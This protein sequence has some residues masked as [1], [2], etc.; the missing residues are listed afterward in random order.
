VAV[1]P[2]IPSDYLIDKPVQ[3]RFRGTSP[4]AH[5]ISCQDQRTRTGGGVV[6][7]APGSSAAYRELHR[8]ALLHRQL[9]HEIVGEAILVSLYLLVQSFQRHAVE[10]RKVAV[11]HHPVVPEGERL[12]GHAFIQSYGMAGCVKRARFEVTICDLKLWI[13]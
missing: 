7:A 1:F 2:A 10:F 9:K 8:F 4:I 6:V 13:A 5:F 12:L 3:A 11:E